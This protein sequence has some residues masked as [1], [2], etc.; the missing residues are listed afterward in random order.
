MHSRHVDSGIIEQLLASKTR[1]WVIASS[2]DMA[3]DW[4]FSALENDYLAHA[5]RRG[6]LMFTGRDGQAKVFLLQ[7]A[8]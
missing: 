4:A 8:D 2:V 7:A 6:K 5:A 1:T 3:D